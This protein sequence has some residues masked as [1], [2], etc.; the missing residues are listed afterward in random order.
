V[1]AAATGFLPASQHAEVL[2]NEVLTHPAHV[3]HVQMVPPELTQV[4]LDLA[5]LSPAL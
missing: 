2:G 4:L 3:H 1:H 5:A